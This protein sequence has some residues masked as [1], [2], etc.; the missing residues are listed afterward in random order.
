MGRTGIILALG[1]VVAGASCGASDGERLA[2]VSIEIRFHP[3]DASPASSRA[4]STTPELTAAPTEYDQVTR[5]LLDV[6][7]VAGD[8]PVYINFDLGEATPDQWRGEL[9]LVPRDQ[10]LRF[11][12]RALDAAGQ[13][14]FSGETFA[15]LVSDNAELEIPLAPAQDQ[16]TFPMPRMLR[17]VY[18][19]VLYSGQEEQMSFTLQGNA[20][21][22]IAVRIS[23]AGTTTPAAEVSPATGTLTLTGNVADFVTVYTPPEVATET[24]LDYQI[25]ITLD[26]G[27]SAVAITTRFQVTVQPRAPGGVVHHAR[28]RVVFN[29]VIRSLTAMRGESPGTVELFAEVRDDSAPAQLSYQ[30]SFTPAEGSPA[31]T[32]ADGGA[33]NP[34]VFQGYTLAHQGLI[35]LAVTDEDAGNTTL[36][37]QLVPNQFA[38]AIDHDAVHGIKHIVAGIAHTCALTGENRVRCWGDN[39]SGQ[40][41]YG[42]S[43]DV[44]D[45]PGRL[46][47]QAGDVPLPPLDPVRQ[48]VAGNRHTCALLQS[49][50]VVCWGSNFAG[51]LGYGH[52]RNIGD[53]EPV[54]ASG[55]VT[56]GGLA[57]KI[58]AGS[59]HTCAILQSGAVRCW[60]SNSL[61]QLGHGTTFPI[62]DD[63][64]VASAGNVDLG[65]GVTVQQLALGA[66]HTCA[67]LSSGKVRCWGYNAHGQ[68]G[69]GHTNHLGDNEGISTLPDVSL[70]GSVR[71]LVARGLH[72][73]ALTFSGTLRCWGYN[74]YGQLGQ[75][76]AVSSNW[77]DEAH[78]LPSTLPGDIHTGAPITDVVSGEY[79]VCAQSSDGQLKC[80]GYNAHGQLGDG[81]FY[82]SMPRPPTTGVNLDGVSAHRIAAG[83]FHTCALRSNGTVRCWGSGDSGQLGRGSTANS[84]TATGNVDI[85]ILDP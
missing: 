75:Q 31:A 30:W 51:Q 43:N 49:G 35:S 14:A 26:G 33:T 12:A 19:A 84:A 41:G 34:G 28:P 27:Q 4:A 53:G 60:G 17:I 69:Y 9:P 55:Y 76:V 83:L 73:C 85:S 65:P 18:P 78:E 5:V 44:G 38:S 45:H 25:T 52:T 81:G 16:Q 48:L 62:G 29:P 23:P 47:Y 22:A 3:G 57:T 66:L 6:T 8:V 21:A 2:P 82:Q 74:A 11:S 10:P 59:D 46:P 71:K 77:G 63:E 32:F 15:T 20:G 42:H 79:H 56:L 61:G 80:W 72:T 54:T 13:V 40:L 37:Y 24:V 7:R 39:E 68:L 67:L 1:L 64:T 70:T 36:H 58:A 50:L